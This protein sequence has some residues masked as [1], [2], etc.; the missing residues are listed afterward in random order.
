VG[1]DAA[2]RTTDQLVATIG[3]DDGSSNHAIPLARPLAYPES[4]LPVDPYV[5]GVWLGDGDRDVAGLT[6]QLGALGVLGDKH[7]PDA[8]LYAAPAQRLALLQGLTDTGGTNGEAGRVMFST[9]T[10]RWPS[11]CC[12]RR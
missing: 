5:L 6:A 12:G 4:P 3:S 9:P 2:T 1:R 7:I 10:R 11:W 8:Y